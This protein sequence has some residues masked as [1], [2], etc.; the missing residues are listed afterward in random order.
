MR[1]SHRVGSQHQI[2]DFYQNQPACVACYLQEW[3]DLWDWQG[4]GGKWF[5]Y[6]R[7]ALH[8]WLLT[9]INTCRSESDLRSCEAT[10]ISGCKESPEKSEAFV[11]FS[12]R[13]LSCLFFI[14]SSQMWFTSYTHHLVNTCLMK[15]F[16]LTYCEKAKSEKASYRY[17]SGFLRVLLALL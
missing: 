6:T 10:L 5:L 16:L 12:R 17:P 11:A 15:Y 4:E 3:R 13:S 9:N 8:W 1:A 14:C 7:I 2:Y